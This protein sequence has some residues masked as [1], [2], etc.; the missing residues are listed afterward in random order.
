MTKPPIDKLLP[1][2]PP[3]PFGYEPRKTLI[4]NLSG[5]L[6]KTDFVFGKG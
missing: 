4:L 2:I 5:T 6:L 1:D 3:L